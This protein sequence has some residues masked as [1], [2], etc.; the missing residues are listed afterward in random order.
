VPSAR[1]PL[2]EAKSRFTHVCLAC[3]ALGV[4]GGYHDHGNG[5]AG[6]TIPLSSL[7]K[8]IRAFQAIENERDEL[9]VEVVPRAEAEALAEALERVNLVNPPAALAAYRSRHSKEKTP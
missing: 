3:G 1:R 6:D 7:P 9:L 2:Q 8:L 5:N 4:A